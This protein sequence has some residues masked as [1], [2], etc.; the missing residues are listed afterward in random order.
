MDDEWTVGG[1]A[2]EEHP[3]A[4]TEVLAR[5]AR[6]SGIRKFAIGLTLTM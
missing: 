4:M 6:N 1:G 5:A 2:D 3:A